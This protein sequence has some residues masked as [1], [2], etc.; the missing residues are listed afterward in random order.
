MLKDDEKIVRIYIQL[1]DEGTPIIR[2]SNAEI[3]GENIYL[4]LPFTGTESYKIDARGIPRDEEWEFLPGSKVK[5]RMEI[6][7]GEERLVAYEQIEE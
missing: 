4:V 2:W 7:K 1:L 3:L 5:C 6:W